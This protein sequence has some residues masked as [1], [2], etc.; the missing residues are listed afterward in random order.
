MINKCCSRCRG[1]MYDRDIQMLQL[2][3]ANVDPNQF[4]IQLIHKFGLVSLLKYW[5]NEVSF[6]FSLC[7]CFYDIQKTAKPIW[8][9]FT[10]KL[11]IDP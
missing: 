7:F 4:L 5:G 10:E 8:L 11:L 1:E 6:L 2:A 9:S 3:A